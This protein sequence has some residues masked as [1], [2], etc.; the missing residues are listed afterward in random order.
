MLT[1]CEIIRHAVNSHFTAFWIVLSVSSV[2][3][4]GQEG[5]IKKKNLIHR[6]KVFK[7]LV[8]VVLP[9]KVVY[10]FFL[11]LGLIRLYT[12]FAVGLIH[13][14]LHSF[15]FLPYFYNGEDKGCKPSHILI[16]LINNTNAV[17][18]VIRRH[19]T[20][21]EAASVVFFKQPS[22]KS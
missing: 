3:V 1:T 21:S 6:C 18:I 20:G 15:F 16:K 8:R 14:K 12:V 17:V 2:C 9:F 11:A 4:R 19:V 5:K 10:S 13:N 22:L 7:S